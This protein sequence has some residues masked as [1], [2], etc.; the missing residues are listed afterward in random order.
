MMFHRFSPFTNLEP[1]FL[2]ETS[3]DVKDCKGAYTDLL[4]VRS[5]DNLPHVFTQIQLNQLNVLDTAF[6]R[7]SV[8]NVECVVASIATLNFKIQDA[9]PIC[10]DAPQGHRCQ[11]NIFG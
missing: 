4:S 8:V 11:H 6:L 3:D 7:R 10:F 9:L 5:I 1:K 2:R